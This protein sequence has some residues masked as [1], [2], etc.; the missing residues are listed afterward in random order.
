MD[1]LSSLYGMKVLDTPPEDRF[2]RIT[3]LAT[4]VFNVPIS[5]VTLV[6]SNREWYK[7]CRGVSEKEHDRTISFCD[8]AMMSESDLFVVNDTK[9]DPRFSNNPMVVGSPF[10]RFYAGVPLFSL[11]G[12]RIGAFCIKDIKP[13]DLSKNEQLL[14]ETLASWAEIE[15]NINQLN[16]ILSD[17]SENKSVESDKDKINDLVARLLDRDV[18]K[19]IRSLKINIKMLISEDE[20]K[21]IDLNEHTFDQLEDLIF[22]LEKIFN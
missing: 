11:D 17:I 21:K 18:L 15:L 13:R 5:T 22:R 1:R 2:D 7:S 12:K 19:N 14:L 4:K 16:G 6:D 8:H 3:L 9:K 20:Q 10:I